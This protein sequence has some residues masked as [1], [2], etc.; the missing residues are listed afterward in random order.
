VDEHVVADR[1]LLPVE[2]PHVDVAPHA[3]DLDLRDGV[4][5]VHY[6]DDLSRYR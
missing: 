5:L 4:L 1:R 6:L 2:H 3:A